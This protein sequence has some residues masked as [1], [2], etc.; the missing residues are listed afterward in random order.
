MDTTRDI[1]ITFDILY[2]ILRNEKNKEE[3]QQLDSLFYYRLDL[4]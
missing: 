4:L 3:L 2:D 1:K